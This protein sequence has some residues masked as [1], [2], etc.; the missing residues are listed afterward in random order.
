MHAL[1]THLLLLFV[2]VSRIDHGDKLK[3][4][5]ALLYILSNLGESGLLLSSS[6]AQVLIYLTAVLLQ[7]Y[8]LMASIFPL[9]IGRACRRLTLSS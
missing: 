1:H 4:T 5:T 9:E 7:G 8:L 6:I 3:P 2:H